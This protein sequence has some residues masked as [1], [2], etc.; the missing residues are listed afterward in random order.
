MCKQP[1]FNSE[2]RIQILKLLPV[3]KLESWINGLQFILLN[4]ANLVWERLI[5]K[6]NTKEELNN[7]KEEIN[8]A[9][10]MTHSLT[11]YISAE[12]DMIHTF[13]RPPHAS[14]RLVSLLANAFFI[15]L[16]E[17]KSHLRLSG[18]NVRKRCYGKVTFS[19]IR[20]FL[21]LTV[22]VVTVRFYLEFCYLI[23]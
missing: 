10:Q 8:H 18:N 5:K 22:I 21:W 23:K 4:N 14:F 13:R 15:Q 1:H 19:Q 20:P 7:L 9:S 2:S 6:I 3:Y 16:S 12:H 11:Y 17:D